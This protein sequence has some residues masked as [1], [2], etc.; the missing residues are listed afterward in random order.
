MHSASEEIVLNS[1][2]SYVQSKPA[3][4]C[5]IYIYIYIYINELVVS[6]IPKHGKEES[7]VLPFFLVLKILFE[8]S[9]AGLLLEME[10]QTASSSSQASKVTDIVWK[11]QGGK[12]F[13]SQS[14]MINK[15]CFCIFFLMM[16]KII[17]MTNGRQCPVNHALWGF[18]SQRHSYLL[19]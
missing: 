17:T 11:D 12:T 14:L 4:Y 19:F 9:T 6:G 3:C 5:L 10:H 16:Q 7:T 13:F 15:H 18:P 2:S 1:V 8:S